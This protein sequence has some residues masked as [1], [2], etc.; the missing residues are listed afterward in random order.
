[1]EEKEYEEL[2]RLF[3]QYCKTFDEHVEFA[4]KKYSREEIL[5]DIEGKF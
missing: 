5:I 4:T 3:W 1:M 2:G